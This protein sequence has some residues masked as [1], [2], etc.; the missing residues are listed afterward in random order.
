MIFI[1]YL[2]IR[3]DKKSQIR[4]EIRRMVYR[5]VVFSIECFFFGSFQS[6]QIHRR[7]TSLESM[8]ES[9]GILP[10][11]IE[12]SISMSNLF[13]QL[14]DYYSFVERK[15]NKEIQVHIDKLRRQI[16]DITEETRRMTEDV[17]LS[18]TKLQEKL[19][20]LAQAKQS[21]QITRQT[22][23]DEVVAYIIPIRR[24]SADEE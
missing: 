14:I 9:L 4:T 2:S 17:E 18:Q 6:D 23:L 8:R 7:K 15:Q 24:I 10:D 19:N 20:D 13:C 5:S 11:R 16:Q 1:C 22:H 3:L 21:L 12:Q